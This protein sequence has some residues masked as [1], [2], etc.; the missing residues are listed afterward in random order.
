[1]EII[2]KSSNLPAAFMRELRVIFRTLLLINVLS[3]IIS[4]FFSWYIID[5]F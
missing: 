5:L 3:H 4:T 2:G 1:M